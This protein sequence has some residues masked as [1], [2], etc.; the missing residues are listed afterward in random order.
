MVDATGMRFEHAFNALPKP[1]R[2]QVDVT[3]VGGTR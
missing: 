1:K 3:N 2:E